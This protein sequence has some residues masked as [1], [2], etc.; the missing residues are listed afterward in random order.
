MRT[1]RNAHAAS[2]DAAGADAANTSR[3]R[4]VPARRRVAPLALTDA[5]RS[6]RRTQ[7]RNAAHKRE[8]RLSPE[9]REKKKKAN[10]LAVQSSRA[11]SKA[12][13][14]L[15]ALAAGSIPKTRGR[16]LRLS[17]LRPL[18]RRIPKEFVSRVTVHEGIRVRERWVSA[19]DA[20]L[21][22]TANVSTPEG[23]DGDAVER[24]AG[25]WGELMA[26]GK[27]TCEPD[28]A[29]VE[30]IEVLNQ[31]VKKEGN[32]EFTNVK[33]RTKVRP[34]SVFV[35]PYTGGPPS[36][37]ELPR[38]HYDTLDSGG[39][40]DERP[41]FSVVFVLEGGV[42][43]SGIDVALYTK[44]KRRAPLRLEAGDAVVLGPYVRH[45]VLFSSDVRDA[46]SRDDTPLLHF[47]SS[48][49]EWQRRLSIVA[50]YAMK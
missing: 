45:V 4:S 6:R 12:A 50:F 43:E 33:A 5:E 48:E 28:E 23:P 20:F 10:T 39:V 17:P 49:A 26:M 21:A 14:A 36:V 13:I 22:S 46:H 29:I 2:T 40:R 30:L 24:R 25:K 41:C 8:E 15:Q 32:A 1:P 19:V 35:R 7:L 38:V 11:R 47:R 34:V 16:A 9:Q 27:Y 44:N 18:K 37:D 42:S 31:V 3:N